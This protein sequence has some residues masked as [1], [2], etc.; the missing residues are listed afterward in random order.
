M[1]DYDGVVTIFVGL[2][3]IGMVA[4]PVALAAGVYAMYYIGS[5]YTIV[6]K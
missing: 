6:S 4:I 1:A 2:A 5:H 3:Y